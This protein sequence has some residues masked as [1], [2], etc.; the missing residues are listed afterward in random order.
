MFESF[1][2]KKQ[3]KTNYNQ[4]YN[5]KCLIYLLSCKICGVQYESS[6]TDPFLYHQNNYKD[7]NRKPEREEE[8]I[9]ADLFQH[10][11]SHGH[12]NFLKDYAITLI[13][14][15]YDADSTRTEEHWRTLMKT[16]PP[17]GLNIAAQKFYILARLLCISP[18]QGI[19]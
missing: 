18:R 2:T 13:D 8:H 14:K 17:Y 12:S 4:N 5:N 19:Y 6:T 7:N 16:V 1:Q 11:A 15:T 10:F 9:Q 3:Q